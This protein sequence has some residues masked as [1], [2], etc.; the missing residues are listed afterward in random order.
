MEGRRL[1]DRR[2]I[3]ATVRRKAL[4][5]HEA[6]NLSPVSTRRSGASLKSGRLGRLP[7]LTSTTGAL[8]SHSI[9]NRI[10]APETFE[11]GK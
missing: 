10:S 4:L 9:V 2:L 7:I 6:L 8:S 1:D 11:R 5:A 3:Q